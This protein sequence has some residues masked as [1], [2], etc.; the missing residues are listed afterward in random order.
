MK[1]T[2]LLAL[3]ALLFAFGHCGRALTND[4]QSV[5]AKSILG[6]RVTT[7]ALNTKTP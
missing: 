5:S 7:D 2:V 3:T 1:Q 6:V 4:F